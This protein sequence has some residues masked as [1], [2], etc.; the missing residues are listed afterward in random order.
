MTEVKILLNTVAK[1][2]DFADQITKY[3]CDCDIVSGNYV[4]DAKSIMG[5]FSLDVSR[6]INLRIHEDN[7]DLS[8]IQEF[9]FS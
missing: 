7:A 3:P 2:K 9:I 8:R 5:I 6:P 4:I 1:V